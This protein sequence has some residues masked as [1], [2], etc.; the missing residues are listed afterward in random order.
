MQIKVPDA[1]A[2]RVVE[3]E[4]ILANDINSEHPHFE[5]HKN[6]WASLKA[7]SQATFDNAQY[8]LPKRVGEEPEIY[9]SR[10]KKLTYNPVYVQC[11]LAL[12]KGINKGSLTV[13]G[14]DISP[15]RLIKLAGEVAISLAN[16]G[17]VWLSFDVDGIPYQIEPSLICDWYYEGGVLQ[18]VKSHTYARQHPNPIAP[19]I[20]IERYQVWT[21]N[22]TT[23]YE[24]DG[25]EFRIVSEEAIDS[26]PFVRVELPAEQWLGKI[27]FTKLRQ[28]IGVESSLSDASA[29]LYIQRT[30]ENS[31]A[32]PDDDLSDTYINA[33][34][35]ALYTSNAYI[36][37]GKFS[38]A[39]ANGT[40]ISR[41]LELVAVIEKQVRAVIGLDAINQAG[42][43][44]SGESKRYD[45]K[46]YSDVLSSL[47]VVITEGLA[48]ALSIYHKR[49]V[50]VEGLNEFEL[51]NLR[52]MLAIEPSVALASEKI[53]PEYIDAW[54]KK[55]GSVLSPSI[56]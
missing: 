31:Q 15:S 26:I 10:L 23:V 7:L 39:E 22:K 37:S 48:Q 35:D 55:L 33:R 42:A 19:A 36:Y 17:S 47:G 43:N 28:L 54:Y 53:T 6:T 32:L 11:L 45:F 27:V 29:N 46:D 52:S 51:D 9:A 40:S 13:K 5:A 25:T 16:Y 34:P 18:W 20:Q 8:W 3:L 14:A 50:E 49:S 21:A 2:S 4:L 44:E 1:S 38:F 56:G 30:V 12:K 41:N 24:S